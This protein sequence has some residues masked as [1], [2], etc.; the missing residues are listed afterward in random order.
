MKKSSNEML[1]AL[2]K[3]TK[4]SQ[5]SMAQFTMTLTRNVISTADKITVKTETLRWSSGGSF[6]PT[7]Q[8]GSIVQR[9]VRVRLMIQVLF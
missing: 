7:R 6:A 1:L 8:D 5:P 9:L 2:A 4:N 3:F